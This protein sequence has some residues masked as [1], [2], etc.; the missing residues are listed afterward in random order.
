MATILIA[1]DDPHTVRV[2]SMWLKRHGHT[3]LEARDGVEALQVLDN[4]AVGL[5]IS[6]INMP[7]LDG[8]ALLKAVREERAL[9]VPFLML[10]SRCDQAALAR[11]MEPYRAQLSPKPFVPSRLVADV[12]RMLS[13]HTVTSPQVRLKD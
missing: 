1:D 8:L 13:D 12:E 5:I 6:D 11:W 3:V 7:S 9:D 4:E 10:S 2:M